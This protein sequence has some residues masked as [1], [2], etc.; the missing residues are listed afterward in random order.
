MAELKIIDEETG[1][2][3]KKI[4]AHDFCL[5]NNYNIIFAHEDYFQYLSFNGDFLKEIR[6]ESYNFFLLN[7]DKRCFLY[8][9]CYDQLCFWDKYDKNTHEVV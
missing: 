4:E 1:I 8:N 9:N 2:L 6:F 7:Y 5:D 3:L